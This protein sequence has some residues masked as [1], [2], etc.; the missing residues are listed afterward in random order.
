MI[1]NYKTR[2]QFDEYTYK[3]NS[4]WKAKGIKKQGD[5]D[6]LRMRDSYGEIK[7]ND[8]VYQKEREK[9][10][11]RNKEFADQLIGQFGLD[12]LPEEMNKLG[13]ITK[14]L[15]KNINSVGN[16]VNNAVV[17]TSKLLSGLE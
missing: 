15:D 17:G 11:Q 5:P 4:K 13:E 7:Y 2:D 16:N 12:K 1:R 6:F 3:Y 14:E 8:E 9:I 10:E